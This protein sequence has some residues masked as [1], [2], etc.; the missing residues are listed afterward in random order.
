MIAIDKLNRLTA[1]QQKTLHESVRKFLEENFQEVKG[2]HLT[3]DII[4]TDYMTKTVDVCKELSI[5]E[6]K[7]ALNDTLCALLTSAERHATGNEADTLVYSLLHHVTLRY[8]QMKNVDE[9]LNLIRAFQNRDIRV[10]ELAHIVGATTAIML[11]DD[12]VYVDYSMPVTKQSWN[13]IRS[14]DELHFEVGGRLYMAATGDFYI[15]SS[16]D[17]IGEE[18]RVSGRIR[19]NR[20]SCSNFTNTGQA[21]LRC[22]I[23][24]GSIDWNRDINT[25]TA[26][27]RNSWMLGL[28]ELKDGDTLLHVYPCQDEDK[29]YMVVESLT[30]TTIQ[31][32]EEYVYSVALTIGFITGTIHL[33]KCYEFSSPELEFGQGVVMSYHTMRPSSETGMKIF[34]T[35]MYYVCETL[36]SAKVNLTD[37]TPLYNKDGKFQKHLQDWLQP[38]M[39]QKLFNLIHGDK[40]VARAVVTLIESANFPL[41]YQ[42]SVRAIVLETLAHSEPG[43]RPITDEA[44]WEEI[45]TEMDSIIVKYKYN[46]AG[47]QQI[48]ERS[49]TVLNKKIN[50]MNNPTNADSL[51]RPLEEA[52]YLL[53]SNDKKALKMRDTFL[54]GGLVKGSMEIQ[55]CELFYLSLMLHKL[56]CIII[57]KRAGFNGYI[58]NNP[59]LFNCEKAITAGEKPLILI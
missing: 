36:K 29:K 49:L 42:A 9:S 8:Q 25:Y 55:T 52:G 17:D 47:E 37:K 54:H 39:M 48:S 4:L 43:P 12:I 28:I 13:L 45:K 50:S 31:Q 32:M 16:K 30:E 40:K 3:D 19:I 51:A 58:L 15:E 33:G 2:L 24:V 44:L 11:E 41:E 57:L 5:S 46:E 10:A 6:S 1:G 53:N 18:G 27:I 7:T 22:L 23:P 59:V 38:D 26:F 34:T 56:A 21:F 35:N 20:F 14:L